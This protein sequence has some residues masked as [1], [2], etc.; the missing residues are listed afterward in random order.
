MRERR[1]GL[2]FWKKIKKRK[3]TQSSNSWATVPKASAVSRGP[4]L[5]VSSLQLCSE[6]S[7]LNYFSSLATAIEDQT[8][9]STFLTTTKDAEEYFFLLVVYRSFWAKSANSLS[10]C[11]FTSP[12]RWAAAG[13]KVCR[14]I[15]V[16]RSLKKHCFVLGAAAPVRLAR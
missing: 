7:L 11:L 4:K 15:A 16:K 13:C 3:E 5:G 1:S 14:V 2:L 9:R 8:H 12:S 6:S 10:F